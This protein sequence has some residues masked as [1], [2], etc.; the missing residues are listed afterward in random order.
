MNRIAWLLKYI[1]C[2]L[3][4]SFN[5]QSLIKDSPGRLAMKLCEIKLRFLFRMYTSIG[6][7]RIILHCGTKYA[8]TAVRSRTAGQ[9]QPSVFYCYHLDIP[10]KLLPTHICPRSKLGTRHRSSSIHYE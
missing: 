7:K 5:L 3:F 10:A 4:N 8:K 9:Y 2:F 1:A 6:L